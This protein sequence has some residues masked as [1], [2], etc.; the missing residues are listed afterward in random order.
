MLNLLE[1]LIALT[2]LSISLLGYAEVELQVLKTE[3][4]FQ[5]SLNG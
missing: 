2:L 1:V 3:R 4:G 5:R